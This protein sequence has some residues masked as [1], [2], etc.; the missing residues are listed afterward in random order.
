MNEFVGKV[1]PFCKT[2]FK[3]DDEIVVCS[4]CDMPHHKDCWVENKGCTTFGCLGTIK[5][6]DGAPSTVTQRVLQYDDAEARPENNTISYCGRCGSPIASDSMYC[7]KCGTRSIIQVIINSR[8]LTL[9]TTLSKRI[10]KMK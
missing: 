2:A 9:Q 6:P 10:M 5:K 3:E 7:P 8:I 1:C 4:V